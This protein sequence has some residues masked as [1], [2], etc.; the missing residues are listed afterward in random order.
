MESQNPNSEEKLVRV[1]KMLHCA[2]KCGASTRVQEPPR[3]ARDV[4]C[5]V[6][7]I[8]KAVGYYDPPS[9]GSRNDGAKRVGRPSRTAC[10]VNVVPF[11]ARNRAL[12]VLCRARVGAEVNHE[13]GVGLLAGNSAWTCLLC[14]V[15]ACIRIH[16]W[17]CTCEEGCVFVACVCVCGGVHFSG[18]RNVCPTAHKHNCGLLPSSIPVPALTDY[19][20]SHSKTVRFGAGSP[21]FRCGASQQSGTGSLRFSVVE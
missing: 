14:F 13:G 3:V 18:G 16:L 6:A 10:D 20:N 11:R 12:S 19:T 4:R 5:G 7:R 9:W 15:E 17:E 1:P 21:S 8:L 2:L